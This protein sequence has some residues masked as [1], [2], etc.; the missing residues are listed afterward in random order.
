MDF[1]NSMLIMTC[2]SS[3][4]EFQNDQDTDMSHLTHR[5]TRPF[6]TLIVVVLHVRPHCTRAGL[7]SGP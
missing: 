3:L 1:L 6:Q 7:P 2:V 4:F 5:T